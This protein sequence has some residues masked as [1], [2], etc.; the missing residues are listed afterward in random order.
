M[1]DDSGTDFKQLTALAGAWRDRWSCPIGRDAHRQA[2]VF[3][4]VGSHIQHGWYSISGDLLPQVK[5]FGVTVSEKVKEVAGIE[6]GDTLTVK[7]DDAEGSKRETQLHTSQQRCQY[8]YVHA[9]V[10]RPPNRPVFR[11]S[12]IGLLFLNYYESQ[13][14]GRSDALVATCAPTTNRFHLPG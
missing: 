5:A 8:C 11:L 3:R 7:I 13:Q 2:I 6:G 10:T 14:I 9:R 12:D 1:A 4:C